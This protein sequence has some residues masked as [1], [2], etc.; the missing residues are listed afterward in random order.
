[1]FFWTEHKES[2]F[3]YFSNYLPSCKKLKK[4][5]G[6]SCKKIPNWRKD[7]YTDGQT[8]NDDFSGLSV[9][10]GSKKGNPLEK[11]FFFIEK[12][13]NKGEMGNPKRKQ[14]DVCFILEWRREQI[15]QS[16]TINCIR[17]FWECIQSSIQFTR[18]LGL[19]NK[20][21]EVKNAFKAQTKK[22]ILPPKWAFFP[23]LAWKQK[24]YFCPHY[25]LRNG[26]PNLSS[27]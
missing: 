5:N 13:T 26:W 22:V 3:V 1:M 27:N 21:T 17:Q 8:D 14:C 25:I 7:R 23:P 15:F 2:F 20:T 18:A 16:L 24:Y 9:G 11:L 10:W 6:H 4:L 12:K 19:S